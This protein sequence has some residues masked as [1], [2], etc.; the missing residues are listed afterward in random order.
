M[1]CIHVMTHSNKQADGLAVQSTHPVNKAS[2][3]HNDVTANSGPIMIGLI[4][5]IRSRLL[6]EEVWNFAWMSAG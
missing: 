5:V 4:G 1:I 6:K 2:L 3:L